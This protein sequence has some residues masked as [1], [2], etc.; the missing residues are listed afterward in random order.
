[1]NASA[2][3]VVASGNL[4]KLEE[5]RAMLGRPVLGLSDVPGAPVPVED[6]DTFEDNARIK[7]LS[8]FRYGGR[9][10][11]ADDSGLEVDALG[12]APGVHSAY[13][14]GKHGDHAANNARLLREMEGVADRRARF[15]CVLAYIGEDGAERIYR[16]VCEGRIAQAP[17]GEGGFGYDPLFIPEGET[18]TFAELGGEAKNRLS[19]RARALE[20]FAADQGVRCGKK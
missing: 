20:A 15:V 17:A 7:A 19:H 2:A 14:G 9:A 5:I 6:G 4:H 1:M 11:L 16:G 10:A 3:L 13:Y 12:G 8:L 18:R